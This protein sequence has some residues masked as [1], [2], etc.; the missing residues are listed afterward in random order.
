MKYGYTKNDI[1]DTLQ[2]IQGK[3]S[4]LRHPIVIIGLLIIIIGIS[5]TTILTISN[6]PIPQEMISIRLLSDRISSGSPLNAELRHSTT[7]SMSLELGVINN[8]GETVY[9]SNLPAD[10]SGRS[11]I[12]IPTNN[13]PDGS[14]SLV[15]RA[16]SNQQ[17]W[18]QSEDF[19]II[20]PPEFTPLSDCF[21]GIKDGNEEGIDCGGSCFP[22]QNICGSCDDNDPCTEDSCEQGQCK[23]LSIIPCCGDGICQVGEECASDCDEE[24]LSLTPFQ[25]IERAALLAKDDAASAALMC[26]TIAYEDDRSVCFDRIARI[27]KK[28]TLC[29]RVTGRLQSSCY[30]DFAM[31]GDYSV[32][33]KIENKYLRSSCE[34]LASLERQNQA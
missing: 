19:T 8:E 7:Q 22:C 2:Y 15:V 26:D 28:S 32:C 23:H 6:K 13:L 21:N 31:N 34:G 27:S 17:S 10:S 18:S 12:T 3:K 30:M 14:Y 29:E 1:L 16:Y 11:R 24:S 4:F 5:I 20:T 9:E 25:V 33:S